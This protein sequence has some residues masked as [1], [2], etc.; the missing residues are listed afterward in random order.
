MSAP[1]R[2]AESLMALIAERGGGRHDIGLTK[3][4]LVAVLEDAIEHDRPFVVGVG[5]AEGAGALIL[6]SNDRHYEWW[7]L[8]MRDT[9]DQHRKRW[10]EEKNERDAGV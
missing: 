6:P 4:D 3:E 5:D 7:A 10:F 8:V 2:T 1:E 9:A